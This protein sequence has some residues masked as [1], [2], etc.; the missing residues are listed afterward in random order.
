MSAS[1]TVVPKGEEVAL[2]GT[3]G[4]VQRQFW[5]S[6]LWGELLPATRG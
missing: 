6:Q 1:R 4:H 5:L 3:F 2:C